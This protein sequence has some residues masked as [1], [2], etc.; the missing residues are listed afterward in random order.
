MVLENTDNKFGVVKIT[1]NDLETIINFTYDDLTSLE[2]KDNTLVA[3]KGSKY[4]LI[5]FSD[6]ALTKAITKPI[7]DYDDKHIVVKMVLLII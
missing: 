2:K 4:Y 5:S 6:K 1:S 3:K 7:Y